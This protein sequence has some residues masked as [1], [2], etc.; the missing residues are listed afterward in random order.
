MTNLAET[1]KP[2]EFTRAVSGLLTEE[3]NK[4]PSGEKVTE[5]KAEV[6]AEAKPDT[7]V[8]ADPLLVQILS[9][10]RSHGS[11]G[12]TNF[13]MWLFNYIKSTLS[14]PATIEVEGNILVQTDP[15][16]T[17]LF[18]CHVDTVHS[19]AES[20]GQPQQLAFDPAFGHLFLADKKTSDCLGG[21]DGCGVYILLKMLKAGVKGKFIFHTGEE[22][23]GIG[24]TA[25]V[26]KRAKFCEDLEMVVAFDRAVRTNENPEVILAQGGQKCASTE[27]GEALCKELNKV[28]F[29]LPYVVS[30]KGSFTD[31]KVY[32]NSA[33][34]C[35][36]IGCFYQ[37]QHG[38]DE[39]VD[40]IGLEKLVKAACQVEWNKL[41]IVRNPFVAPPKNDMFNFASGRGHGGA[42][43]G[44]LWHGGDAEP[45]SKG[46]GTL[47]MPPKPQLPVAPELDI[48][49]ELGTYNLEGFTD[50]V[51]GDPDAAVQAL[52]ELTL[53]V[54]ALKAELKCAKTMLGL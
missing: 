43:P 46:K 17:V 42:W 6:V 9:T 3:D 14:L 5:S 33:P 13:R 50:F 54:K 18:S 35:V 48:A 4:K 37:H 12:D 47:T 30:H 29:D 41:P 49:D 44:D 39:Y 32:R 28:D 20:T 26:K 31:S 16:S 23:G 21:D 51:V 2:S 25:F 53:R 24:S 7:E 40:V 8:A 19:K 34:E 10:R 1:K 45:R 52:V 11:Q 22:R 27:F 36:N 38:P 15:K